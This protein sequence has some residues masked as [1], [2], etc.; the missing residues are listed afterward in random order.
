MNDKPKS[1]NVSI[2]MDLDL[3]RDAETLFANLGMNLS[4]A[5]NVFLRQSLRV[6]G[7]PFPVKLDF[8][9]SIDRGEPQEDSNQE[10]K[11]ESK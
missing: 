1:T 4:T 10:P 2:R 3:K 11:E 8:S 5:F 7:L 9:S 6:Q